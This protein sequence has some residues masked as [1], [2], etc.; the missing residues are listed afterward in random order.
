MAELTLPIVAIAGLID[1]INPCAFG[2]LILLMAYLSRVRD[3][4]AN[5]MKI[6]LIYITAVFLA[7]YIAGLGL[8]RTV[9]ALGIG[10]YVYYFIAIIALVAGILELKDFFWYGRGIFLGI[11][12]PGLRLIKR[13]LKKTNAFGA[14]VLGFV[15]AAVELPCT[16]AVY[17][18]IL[19]MM[20]TKPWG[21]AIWWLFLYNLAFIIP[22]V[23]LFV[24][25]YFGTKTHK[26]EVW[27]KKY[28]KWMRLVTGL[29][30]IALALWMLIEVNGFGL[31][32][33]F[34]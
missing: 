23:I 9:T 10:I 19:A 31:L 1:G 33:L 14:F 24:L 2:V 7:Y 17:L 16:G 30:L 5:L 20:T 29:L 26:I 4:K 18:A 13:Q 32:Y 8:L 25:A 15:V 21:T 28:R 11:P 22:L 3:H 12:A 34:R 27:R 6:C